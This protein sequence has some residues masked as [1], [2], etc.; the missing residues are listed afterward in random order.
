TLRHIEQHRPRRRRERQSVGQRFCSGQSGTARALFKLADVGDTESCTCS[1]LLLRQAYCPTVTFEQRSEG[2]GE[3]CCHAP[4]PMQGHCSRI[5][6]KP[7]R[8]LRI[9]AWLSLTAICLPSP[10]YQPLCQSLCH[11]YLVTHQ[12]AG[13]TSMDLERSAVLCPRRQSLASTSD[14]TL[15]RSVLPGCLLA[16]EHQLP[17]QGD[18][19]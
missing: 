14:L 13:Q 7:Y 1:Q 9:I 15:S 19:L 4:V 6:P 16:H 2:R 18:A 10:L 5:G 17:D 3:C 8:G 11:L 12:S